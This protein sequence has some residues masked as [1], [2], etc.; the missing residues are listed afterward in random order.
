MPENTNATE[1]TNFKTITTVAKPT[2]HTGMAKEELVAGL[3]AYCEFLTLTKFGHLLAPKEYKAPVVD[4]TI[5]PLSAKAAETAKFIRD[6]GLGGDK[7][8]LAEFASIILGEDIRGEVMPEPE[9]KSK[10]LAAVEPGCFLVPIVE[11]TDY[12]TNRPIAYV[13]PSEKTAELRLQGQWSVIGSGWMRPDGTY[14]GQIDRAFKSHRL[15]TLEEITSFISHG[16]NARAIF[17]ALG[18]FDF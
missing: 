8:R 18:G 17:D 1:N 4:A 5:P 15:P 3:A 16:K 11:G 2:Y 10:I 6:K 14:G 9:A 12:K 7:T 13:V